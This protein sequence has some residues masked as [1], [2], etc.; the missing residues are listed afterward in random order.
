MHFPSSIT[1]GEVR[2]QPSGEKRDI[3]RITL[4]H[5]VRRGPEVSEL[6]LD[7]QY[8]EERV[9]GASNLFLILLRQIKKYLKLLYCFWRNALFKT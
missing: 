8:R 7:Q 9:T 6:V 4:V 1:A 2:G 3:R 5:C